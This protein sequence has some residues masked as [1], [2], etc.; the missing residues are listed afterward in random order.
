MAKLSPGISLAAAGVIAVGAMGITGIGI[1][2]G[3]TGHP[4][5]SHGGHRAA[6]ATVAKRPATFQMYANVDAEADLGSNYDAVSATILP[7][8]LEYVVKFVKPIGHCAA[9]VQVG[10]AG[11]PDGITV[12]TPT[13]TKQS[14][15]SF[16]ITFVAADGGLQHDPFM[17]TVTCKN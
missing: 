9:M 5:A 8:S 2:V 6:K 11:G 16:N 14:K 15:R 7:G 10:S 1:G 13:V 3:A 4:T 12:A 17:L